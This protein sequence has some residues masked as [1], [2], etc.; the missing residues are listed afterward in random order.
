MQSEDER[1]HADQY[2]EQVPSRRQGRPTAALLAWL[3]GSA[4]I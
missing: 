3:N 1:R 2:R 4:L